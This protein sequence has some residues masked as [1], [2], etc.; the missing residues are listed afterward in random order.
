MNA[1]ERCA[2]IPFPRRSTGAM[3]RALGVAV[4]VVAVLGM[5]V[6]GTG[7]AM[8]AEK[9]KFALS[10]TPTGRD[11][12]FYVALDR[13]FF[14]EQGLEVE[15]LKGQGSGDTIKRVSVGTAVAGDPGE[16][17]GHDPRPV[18]VRRVRPEGL[19]YS[20]AQGPGGEADRLAGPERHPHGLPGLRG[21]QP[22][23]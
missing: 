10:W 4:V 2:R 23:G 1:S 22:R 11:A 20:E 15:S 19:R 13:G 14:K 8:A 7:P 21:D 12:G 6:L 17:R 9:V 18:P 3:V 16:G 5:A